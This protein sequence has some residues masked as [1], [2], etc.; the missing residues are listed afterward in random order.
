M[1]NL[2]IFD[3]FEVALTMM[4]IVLGEPFLQF[5]LRELILVLS[6]AAAH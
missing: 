5:N 4:L 3:C 2:D 1:G 6:A